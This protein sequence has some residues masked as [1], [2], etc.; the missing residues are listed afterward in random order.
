MKF[1]NYFGEKKTF[2][3]GELSQK[4]NFKK[5]TLPVGQYAT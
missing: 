2:I 1:N 5:C 4:N 3:T